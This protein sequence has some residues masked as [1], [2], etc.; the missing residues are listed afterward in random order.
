MWLASWLSDP[1][2]L[3]LEMSR[4]QLSSDFA[5]E[6][7]VWFSWMLTIGAGLLFTPDT[8]I[9]YIYNSHECIKCMN[10]NTEYTAPA[11]IFS[12]WN[13]CRMEICCGM[14]GWI[15]GTRGHT[16]ELR[17]APGWCRDS[18]LMRKDACSFGHDTCHGTCAKI[19]NQGFFKQG[20]LFLVIHFDNLD[21]SNN[22]S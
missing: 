2:H 1:A 15:R 21:L 19:S 9:W 14:S 17:C 16:R 3:P 11:H 18:K 4:D 7:V 8:H 6:T 10:K 12:V 22:C 20:C 13:K 5:T